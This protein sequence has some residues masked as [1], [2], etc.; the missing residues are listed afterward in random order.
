MPEAVNKALISSSSVLFNFSPAVII[1][2]GSIPQEPAVGAATILP[3]AALTSEQE[4]ALAIAFII[5]SPVRVF[6]ELAYLLSLI[7][8]PPIKPLID[9]VSFVSP[10]SA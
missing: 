7:A 5:N 6:W 2:A 4:R 10:Y 1:T 8:S 3:I 9:L